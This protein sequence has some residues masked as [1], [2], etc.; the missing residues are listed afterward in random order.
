MAAGNNNVA[1]L[2]NGAAQV[3]GAEGSVGG[4]SY[5]L[6]LTEADG[7]QAPPVN[8]PPVY[9]QAPMPPPVVH[10]PPPGFNMAPP[11]FNWQPAVPQSHAHTIVQTNHNHY[12]QGP[13][14]PRHELYNEERLRSRW[15]P[16]ENFLVHLGADSTLVCNPENK[17]L[18]VGRNQMGE[19]EFSVRRL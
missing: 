7:W 12:T 4:E 19:T 8:A 16:G 2:N 18:V 14:M 9:A 15:Q 3:G 10:V 17:K 6:Q 5:Y 1:P 11:Q 13:L